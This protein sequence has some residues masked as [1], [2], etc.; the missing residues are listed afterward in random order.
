MVGYLASGVKKMIANTKEMY[1]LRLKIE[2]LLLRENVTSDLFNML[3]SKGI[4]RL[5]QMEDYIRQFACSSKKQEVVGLSK[6]DIM[7]NP[8]LKHIQI[9][10][11]HM[12][13]IRLDCG[14]VVLPNR[15]G[16]YQERI[17]NLN[18]FEMQNSYFVCPDTLK[19]PSIL[20][21]DTNAVWMSVEP[22]EIES[23][24]AFIQQASG[25]ILL[26]GCG[27]GYLAYMLSLKPDVKHITILE[28]HPSIVQMF[29]E[30]ILPQFEWK[31]KISIVTTDAMDYLKTQNLQP[32]HFVHMDIWKDTLDMLPLYLE[33]LQVEFSNPTISFSYWLEPTLKDLIQKSILMDFSELTSDV[34]FLANKMGHDLLTQKN[35]IC[36]EDIQRLLALSSMRKQLYDWYVCHPVSFQYLKRQDE[37][38]MEQLKREKRF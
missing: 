18:T 37:Q 30:Y 8:Y 17:R 27:L 36:K 33:C 10:P 7:E 21:G 29:E 6:E 16:F 20:E 15:L 3:V 24:Q 11:V 25:N 23:F 13:N 2:E 28:I 1:E 4:F 26:G 22:C 12:E 9:P 31:D 38:V 35:I 32:Y 34:F 19:F 5:D 14:R